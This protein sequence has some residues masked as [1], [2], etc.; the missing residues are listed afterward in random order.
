MSVATCPNDMK[1]VSGIV[2][3]APKGWCL[4]PTEILSKTRIEF[5]TIYLLH[6]RRSI[7]H[8]ASC[9]ILMYRTVSLLMLA[10]PKRWAMRKMPPRQTSIHLSIVV[11]YPRVDNSD[12]AQW[13]LESPPIGLAEIGEVHPECAIHYCSTSS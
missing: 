10:L 6:S 2:F 5:V 1:R 11:A 12:L 7:C 3:E 13:S 9:R 8:K 4:L